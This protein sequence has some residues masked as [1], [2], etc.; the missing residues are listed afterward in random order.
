MQKAK[1]KGWLFTLVKPF[2]KWRFKRSFRQVNYQFCGLNTNK[3]TIVLCNH[4]SYWDPFMV[5][6]MFITNTDKKYHVMIYEDGL[7]EHPYLVHVG[8]YSI[9]S[10]PRQIKAS[11]DYTLELLNDPKNLVMIFP[12][13]G[14]DSQ[15][16]DYVKFGRGL[17]WLMKEVDPTKTEIVHSVLLFEYFHSL[18]PSANVYSKLSGLPDYKDLNQ[19]SDEYNAFYKEKLTSQ[20]RY[21]K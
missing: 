10:T 15:H 17:S 16:T 5:G 7:N 4:F 14:F 13:A 6:Y 21:L 19:L 8:G 9:G 18:K 3:S 11:F 2:L 12:Q 1:Y 20:F